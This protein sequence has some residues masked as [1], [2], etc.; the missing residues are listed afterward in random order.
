MRSWKLSL[1]V[2]PKMEGQNWIWSRYLRLVEQMEHFQ[3]KPLMSQNCLFLGW[4]KQ[5]WVKQKRCLSHSSWMCSL[6]IVSQCCKHRTGSPGA[7]SHH[8]QLAD[9]GVV[10]ERD[11]CLEISEL[12]VLTDIVF[13]TGVS[14]FPQEMRWQKPWNHPQVTVHIFDGKYL[15]WRV[16][17]YFGDTPYH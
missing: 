5:S 1:T 17:V 13:M 8:V 15:I 2:M 4:K 11:Q 10:P 16:F 12:V 6:Q 9:V 14:E 7:L 3:W